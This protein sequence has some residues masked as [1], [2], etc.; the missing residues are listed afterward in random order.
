MIVMS[1]KNLEILL[2]VFKLE[3]QGIS[4]AHQFFLL[5]LETLAVFLF[6]AIMHKKKKIAMHKYVLLYLFLIYTG[7]LLSLT[8]FRRPEGSREGIVH[9]TVNLGFGLR[10]G[11]PSVFV[12]A[13]SILNI[14][15]FVPHGMITYLASR[16]H[17]RPNGIVISTLL[18][19]AV[20]L[21][22]ECTQLITGRGMFEL[23]DIL[24]NTIGSFTGA[25]LVAV[26]RRLLKSRHDRK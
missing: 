26:I 25:V 21:V 1:D 2:E 7:I 17:K 12:S 24:T 20:S 5:L 15:L 14:L 8:I 11:N 13:F 23:T 10:T 22:I 9:L 19:T 18:G 4:I 16:D 6:W 3:I